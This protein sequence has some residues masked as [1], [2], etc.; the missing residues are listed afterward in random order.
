[1]PSK[2]KRWVG[3]S[4]SKA[5]VWAF[6]PPVTAKSP[7]WSLAVNGKTLTV[8][9]DGTAANAVSLMQAAWSSSQEP[10]FQEIQASAPTSTLS[11]TNPQGTGTNKI[12]SIW[13]AGSPTG[14]S[15]GLT[16]GGATTPFIADPKSTLTAADAGTAGNP[17]GAYEYAFSFTCVNAV[18]QPGETSPSP[19]ASVTV[20]SHEVLLT[21][22][23]L[24]PIGTTGR[25]IYRS[26]A[27]G[28]E[29]KL[30]ASILDNTTS[31]F[32][33]NATDASLGATA[34]A[35]NT[36]GIPYNATAAQLQT[37]LQLL[38][39]AVNPDY[40]GAA[41]CFGDGTQDNPWLVQFVGELGA[42]KQPD[43]AANGWSLNQATVVPALPKLAIDI[44]E[45]QPGVK[46]FDVPPSDG[47]TLV[48][49]GPPGVPFYVTSQVSGT[50]APEI[51]IDLLG[52]TAPNVTV[53]RESES[54]PSITIAPLAPT[55]T[56]VRMAKG[57]AAVNEV[58]RLTVGP[59]VQSGPGVAS[60]MILSWNGQTTNAIPFPPQPCTAA[61]SAT[62]GNLDGKYVWVVT[63]ATQYGETEPSQ[64]TAAITVSNKQVNLTGIP[65]GASVATDRKLYRAAV[66]GQGKV[67]PYQYL[68]TLADNTTTVYAD[69]VADASLPAEGPPTTNFALQGALEALSNTGQGTI[70]AAIANFPAWSG[71]YAGTPIVYDVEFEGAL[72]GAPQSLITADVSS[73]IILPRIQVA[74]VRAGA[75]PENSN[76]QFGWQQQLGYGLPSGTFSLTIPSLDITTGPIAANATVGVVV[77]AIQAAAPAQYQTAFNITQVQATNFGYIW[78]ITFVGPLANTDVAPVTVNVSGLT[79]QQVPVPDTL[80][81]FTKVLNHG[82]V[83]GEDEI[84]SVSL[85]DGASGG[86]FT[87]T[88][89]QINSDGSLSSLGTTAGIAFN[90]NAAAVQ[91]A[92]NAALGGAVANV[93]G[94]GPWSIEFTGSLGAQQLALSATSALTSSG[95]TS[96][97]PPGANTASIATPAGNASDAGAFAAFSASPSYQLTAVNAVGET[98]PQAI[99]D[100]GAA[101]NHGR[102]ITWSAVP[103]ATGYKL[104]RN[105]NVL[106]GDYAAP[107]SIIDTGE[108]ATAAA[109]PG[110][111]TA[112]LGAPANMTFG[113]DNR[114]NV[115]VP[116]AGGTSESYFISAIN[117]TG[118][119]VRNGPF[120][121][122]D[123]NYQYDSIGLIWTPVGGATGYKIYKD[124][125]GAAVF[126]ADIPD[127]SRT[128]WIHVLNGPA[129][130]YDGSHDAWTVDDTEVSIS[131]SLNTSMGSPIGALPP[132][133]YTYF[134]TDSLSKRSS[135]A[136]ITIT[137][138]GQSIK[139]TAGGT[140]AGVNTIIFVREGPSGTLKA[141]FQQMTSESPPQAFDF[142][143]GNA[144][145]NP[146]T[147]GT[148]T[149][150]AP[151]Q[152]APTVGTGQ[153]LAAGTYYYVVTALNAT[154]E[155]TASNE[156]SAVVSADGSV[157]LTWAWLDGA[158]KYNVYRGT[159][160]GS[161]NV[162]IA[163]GCPQPL[164]IGNVFFLDTGASPTAGTPPSVSTA[165]IAAPVQ[166]AASGSTAGGGLASATYY[167]TVTATTALGETT[168]SNEESVAVTGPTGSVAV[169]W[170]DVVGAT[171]YKIYRGGAAGG[172]NVLVATMPAGSTSCIDTDIVATFSAIELV[173]GAAAI[174]ETWALTMSYAIGG[175]FQVEFNGATTG[176]IAYNADAATVQAAMQALVTVGPDNCSAFVS[177]PSTG[178]TSITLVFGGA[179]G[180]RPLPALFAIGQLQGTTA[181]AVS[182]QNAAAGDFTLSFDGSTTGNLAFGASAGAILASLESLNT[183]GVGHV[184]V[185]GSDPWTISF[186][187]SIATIGALTGSASGI[188]SSI[189]DLIAFAGESGATFVL[190]FGG[191]TTAPIAGTAAASDVQAAL[192]AILPGATIT[193]AG[194]AGGPWVSTITLPYG[195]MTGD[196][197]GGISPSYAVSLKNAI[198]GTFTLSYGDAASSTIAYNAAAA[199][200]QTALGAIPSSAAATVTGADGG[201]WQI[202]IPVL[203]ESGATDAPALTGDADFLI[204][205]S[206]T[207]AGYPVIYCFA[208]GPNFWD[209]PGN[210]ADA[211]PPSAYLPTPPNVSSVSPSSIGAN[212]L[213]AGTT[214]YYKATALNAN[215]ETTAGAEGS[216]ATSEAGSVIINGAASGG[217][218][219]LTY[220]GQTTAGIAYNANA[221]AVQS[222][223]QAL[224]SVG[225]G[226]C[227]VTGSGTAAAP[228]VCVFSG[229]ALNGGIPYPLAAVSSLTPANGTSVSV[230]NALHLNLAVSWNRV[231]NA[232]GYKLYRGTAAGGENVLLTTINTPDQTVFIDD[233]TY[234][235][236][237]ASPPT[238][239]S[240]WNAAVG[241][242]VHFLDSAVDCLYNVGSSAVNGYDVHFGNGND[243]YRG[244]Y[245][246][247][248]SAYDQDST[249]TGA[250]GL[251]AANALGYD[252]YRPTQL[253][254]M[255]PP[256]GAFP[257]TI[258]NGD[259]G[260]SPFSNFDFGTCELAMVVN[261]TGS[262]TGS[263]P[264]I[265]VVDA[266]SA[267]ELFL[268]A[269]SIGVA[270]YPGQTSQFDTIRQAYQSSIASDTSLVLGAGVTL[271]TLLKQGGDTLLHNSLT[272]LTIKGGTC[273]QDSGTVGELSIE[274]TVAAASAVYVS[275][276]TGAI[277]TLNVSQGGVF[278]R[279]EQSQPI[280]IA[281]INLYA[282]YALSDPH[283]CV[284]F[285]TLN[286]VKCG[287]TDAID[288]GTDIT[289]ARTQN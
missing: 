152:S 265:L 275:K 261:K 138:L 100:T 227:A 241:D 284:Q 33:D 42:Q 95:E 157:L 37:A 182:L 50:L 91:S 38:L 10:E 31:K 56:A 249:Y 134:A 197:A 6:S 178:T 264:A 201:P 5:G 170:A 114:Y 154:G 19:V 162:R 155:T 32:L 218:Y 215:G 253:S 14:G 270:F 64:P 199:D 118:E 51:K 67:G 35:A 74:E 237:S 174:D 242:D 79:A 36:T 153:S 59:N 120:I 27:G 123:S 179:L 21:G 156:V 282:G 17:N 116:T 224:S 180:G 12:N 139:M 7:N 190:N 82:S 176:E 268:F 177:S 72:G 252:E 212:K 28:S 132:G 115:G 15:F 194:A 46:P 94:G 230:Q 274:P 165:V 16:W 231:P 90:A 54:I 240:A 232:T 103:G 40:A 88:T 141:Q 160:A 209:A 24:G 281:T 183:V 124:V 235:T 195:D 228:F 251:P 247:P 280:A 189:S 39:L 93:T 117:A 112:I 75:P 202:A 161:E 206:G 266:N 140:S 145:A 53:T 66:D 214:Y 23:P 164:S 277:T 108:T 130:S 213:A 44:D 129:S 29:L 125:S 166:S 184:A 200:V 80:N 171:G 89:S 255:G 262:A 137:A 122:T 287:L 105:S 73:V 20:V 62:G 41:I 238:N 128:S 78:Q 61:A 222:A 101:L 43:L 168:A 203:V 257:V 57:S 288:L 110:T 48:L 13:I 77:N 172:E 175:T 211:S 208:V 84:F 259:G 289:L 151:V 169:H 245:R 250:V 185:S 135:S 276:S 263:T 191:H 210:W 269:G 87:L 254:L 70:K 106:V 18:G 226:N 81:G 273:T 225:A 85:E 96:G 196:V 285:T 55:I 220:N 236:A 49:T 30:L 143:N 205:P 187:S 286:L 127:G 58:Q 248:V 52:N 149:L 144:D 192:A 260:G 45:I 142:G 76:Q 216:A 26:V 223:L 22:I 173:H 104:Y 60:T 221:A 99:T 3:N 219:T 121:F 278:D 86:T 256:G 246:L 9:S 198:G 193:V 98:T 97:A 83:T 204:G 65:T 111:A 34:P 188:T 217:T 150:P 167:Y 136:S 126:L 271:N 159:A 107:T 71:H 186:D 2:T 181:Y 234:T 244:I 267:S 113:T 158:T 109:A 233:G 229:T 258:G 272:T 25:N 68:E 63:F 69:N 47:K 1:M 147:A 279:S 8:V 163:T 92:L 4:L 133:A 148:A 239:A 243:A 146:T 207:F 11:Q 131:V 102:E 119:S 283:G